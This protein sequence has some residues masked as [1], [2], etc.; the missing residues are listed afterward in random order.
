MISAA[1]QNTPTRIFLSLYFEKISLL[2]F[3]LSS[4]RVEKRGRESA[5]GV[6]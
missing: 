4:A 6:E 1:S 3:D 2:P 5:E